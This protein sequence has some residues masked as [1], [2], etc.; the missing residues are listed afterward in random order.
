MAHVTEHHPEQKGEGSATEDGRVYFLVR[1]HA[2][3]VSDQLEHLREFVEAEV[4][5]RLNVL[6]RY[7]FKVNFEI[8]CVILGQVDDTFFRLWT[9]KCFDEIFLVQMG[10]KVSIA[11]TTM[12]LELV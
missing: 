6:E 10:P 5:W 9:I 1:G 3:R 2:I 8:T 12:P 7:L 11:D 4:C